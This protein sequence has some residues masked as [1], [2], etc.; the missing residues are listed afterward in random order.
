M[1]ADLEK[2]HIF[3]LAIFRTF[4]M[5]ANLNPEVYWITGAFVQVS[6]ALALELLSPGMLLF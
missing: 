6:K 4:G 2:S 3:N 5:S 1:K